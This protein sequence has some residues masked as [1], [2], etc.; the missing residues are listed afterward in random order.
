[1]ANTC[2]M[3]G[4]SI[5]QG[6]LCSSCDRPRRVKMPTGTQTAA[7]VAHAVDEFPKAPVVP[8]PVEATSPAVTT[9]ADVLIATGVAAIVL[10]SDRS[11]KF[12]TPEVQNLFGPWDLANAKDVERLAGVRIGDLAMAASNNVQ[13]GD[14]HF[15]FSLVPMMVAAGG[16]VLVFRPTSEAPRR[17]V[18]PKVIDIVSAVAN[19]F[20]P[21]ADVKS[22]RIQVDVPELNEQFVDHDQ[23]ADSLGVL[24]E[25]SLQ[26]VPAGGEI[27][28][29]VRLMEHKEKPLLLFFVM[30]TGPLV[31]EHLRQV[32]FEPGFVCNPAA[33]ERTGRDLYKVRDFAGAHAGSVWVDSKSGKTCT[34]FLRVRP[35][36]VR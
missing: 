31:S 10:S 23:L 36:G 13:I 6:I 3:C 19:R 15:V 35:D 28:V 9:I 5:A 24:I 18:L 26:Y 33:S 1:M 8:F 22:I 34:F 7:A 2:L 21:F 29:G 4:A 20:T 12:S 25:N 16:A 32:I 14:H 11:V 30:D 27:V 17:P